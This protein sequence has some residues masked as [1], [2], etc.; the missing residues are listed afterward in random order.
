MKPQIGAGP[1][2]P[3][4]ALAIEWEHVLYVWWA[5]FWRTVVFTFLAGLVAG[6]VLGLAVFIMGGGARTI[7]VVS[8]LVG[9]LVFA[10]TSLVVTRRVLE[11]EF[12]DFRLRVERR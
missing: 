12:S 10:A 1:E 11:M 5:W 3:D 8:G 6:A 2:V 4:L 9:F 7:E